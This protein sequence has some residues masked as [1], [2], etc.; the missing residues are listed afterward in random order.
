MMTA[1]RA[2][3]PAGPVEAPID[4]D[5]V[6]V[7]ARDSAGLAR[8]RAAALH[9]LAAGLYCQSQA[10]RWPSGDIA[11]RIGSGAAVVAWLR[12]YA[13]RFLA[14]LDTAART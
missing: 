12:T 9:E 13:E 2:A 4:W 3:G 14:D 10:E 6:T 11:V 5:S 1:R 7:W 8:L